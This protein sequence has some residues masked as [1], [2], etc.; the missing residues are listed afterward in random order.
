MPIREFHVD[1]VLD[2]LGLSMD[3]FVDLCILLGCDY[4]DKIRGVGPKSAYKM[5]QEH[6]SIENMLKKID[7]K[8]HTVPEDWK[9][10]GA[11]ELF[12]NPEVK[13][14]EECDIKWAYNRT[15]LFK[16]LSQPFLLPQVGEAGRGRPGQVHVRREGIRRGQDQ[17]RGQEAAQGQTGV[18]SGEAGKLKIPAK[19]R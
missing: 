12:K 19:L 16:R 3:Q 11:R 18:Y 2:G 9:F 17:E 14:A 10:E 1:K 5:I 8:K 13:P 15:L 4:C 7:S 6:G